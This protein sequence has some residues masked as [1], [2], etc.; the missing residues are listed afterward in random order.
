MCQ[1][2]T[3]SRIEAAAAQAIGCEPEEIRE[4]TY[5]NY[6]LKVFSAYGLEYAIGTDEQ[7]QEAAS[8]YIKQTLWAF[9]AS[10]IIDHSKIAYSNELEKC[11]KE[12]QGKLCEGCNG[13]VEALIEDMDEFIEDAISADG[14]GHFLSSYDGNEEEVTIDGETFYAYRLN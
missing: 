10:F 1:L 3:I 2:E 8:E 9:N 4:E 14:R 7:A 12:M 5:D 6:G 13:L 11:I